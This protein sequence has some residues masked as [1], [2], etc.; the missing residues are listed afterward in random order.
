MKEQT[1]TL[2]FFSPQLPFHLITPSSQLVWHRIPLSSFASISRRVSPSHSRP[3]FQAYQ[4]GHHLSR[5][6]T[7]ALRSCRSYIEWVHHWLSHAVEGHAYADQAVPPTD[8]S[9]SGRVE[10]IEVDGVEYQISRRRAEN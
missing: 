8:E 3:I 5:H 4:L 2:F 10:G 6:S 9:A 1:S 7:K